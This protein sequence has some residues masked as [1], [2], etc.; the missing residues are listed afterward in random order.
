[1]MSDEALA[2]KDDKMED[3]I[4]A[5]E[6]FLSYVGGLA[7]KN[8]RIRNKTTLENI[9]WDPTAIMI[10][11]WIFQVPPAVGFS[12]Q[13]SAS[14]PSCGEAS[15]SPS[16]SKSSGKLNQPPIMGQLERRRSSATNNNPKIQ[17]TSRVC[18][19]LAT[20]GAM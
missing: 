2:G 1:M 14:S 9:A 4:K 20:H 17:V 15:N 10:I 19:K 11:V 3:A 18:W 13:H 12:L 7:L 8:V 6:D 16:I 5:Q